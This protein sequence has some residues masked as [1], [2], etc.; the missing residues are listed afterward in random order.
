MFYRISDGKEY[1]YQAVSEEEVIKEFPNGII[2]GTFEDDEECITEIG[3]GSFYVC[4]D[5][6]VNKLFIK[7]N[8]R[9]YKATMYGDDALKL[10]RYLYGMGVSAESIF[11]Y[12]TDGII[13]TDAESLTASDIA[14]AEYAKRNGFIPISVLHT[15][16][17]IYTICLSKHV[18][19]WCK[20]FEFLSN[21]I[22]SV[23]AVVASKEHFY[24]TCTVFVKDNA[25]YEIVHAADELMYG[26]KPDIIS[27]CKR[28]QKLLG[29]S[30]ENSVPVFN[31]YGRECE[32]SPSD[33]DMIN[34][35]MQNGYYPYCVLHADRFT[36][37][38][39]VKQN[40]NA[41]SR[42]VV[43]HP[44]GCKAVPAYVFDKV[45]KSGIYTVVYV[46][47][48]F[49]VY[50]TDFKNAEVMGEMHEVV[51]CGPAKEFEANNA[52]SNATVFKTID[53][54]LYTIDGYDSYCVRN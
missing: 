43:D 13:P 25:I 22:C 54:K 35:V 23:T 14:C 5:C 28:R 47:T 1:F 33:I 16:D 10:W 6:T 30:S 4:N 15:D 17:A 41:W 3:N 34:T 45:N 51:A 27:E 39:V 53:N 20:S 48:G 18:S 19:K 49:G 44:L 32:T 42:S 26:V 11:K 9:K 24:T 40:K 38:P 31:G 52:S 12:L 2:I 46:F 37:V 29:I 21:S 50:C 7:V 8:D 36:A